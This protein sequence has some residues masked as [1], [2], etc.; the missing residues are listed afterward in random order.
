MAEVNPPKGYPGDDVIILAETSAPAS[1]VIV[2]LSG[3]KYRMSGSDT[4]WSYRF[5]PEKI[6]TTSF[7]VAA[8]NRNELEGKIQKGD[9][10]TVRPKAKVSNV[11]EAKVAPP[12]GTSGE[13]FSFT[14][15]TDAPAREVTLVIGNQR[16]PMKGSETQWTLSQAVDMEGT[17]PFSIAAINEDGVRGD[18]RKSTLQVKPGIVNVVSISSSPKTGFAGEEYTITVRTDR[19]PTNVTLEMDGKTYKMVGEG[20]NWQLKRQIPDIGKKQFRAVAVNSLGQKGKSLGGELIAKRTPLPIPDVA[21]VDVTVVSPGKGY[22]GTSLP[23][24]HERPNRRPAFRWISKDV[25]TP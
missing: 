15:V 21:A 17:V 5:R 22:A 20:K 8:L 7:R 25:N 16:F 11:L 6:G 23:L 9:I 12:T 18:T 14:A 19:V 24:P 1:E 3:K 10:L 13:K 4:R 2:D